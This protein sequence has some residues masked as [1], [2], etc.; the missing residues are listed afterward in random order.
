MKEPIIVTNSAKK[1]FKNI[2][3]SSNEEAIRFGIKGGGCSGFQFFLEFDKLDNKEPLD[4]IVK[5][6]DL[7]I[8]VDALSMTYI[9]GTTIDWVEDIMGSHFMFNSPNQSSQC[10]C[11]ESISFAIPKSEDSK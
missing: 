1:R 11:G 3:A 8:I 6:D 7:A 9:V 5:I 4:E 2:L 10:G